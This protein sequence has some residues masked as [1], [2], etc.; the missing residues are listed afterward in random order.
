MDCLSERG[1]FQI[2]KD[3][4]EIAAL[5]EPVRSQNIY[6]LAFENITNQPG[7]LFKALVRNLY[8]YTIA[9]GGLNILTGSKAWFLVQ[10][11]TLIGVF[12]CV[13]YIKT[14]KYALLLFVLAGV[15][16]SSTIIT[17]DGGL[18]VF[19]AT[20][21][22]SAAIAAIGINLVNKHSDNSSSFNWSGSA[23]L[24]LL[25][26]LV[27]TFAIML[28]ALM[29]PLKYVSAGTENN[30][31]SSGGTAVTIIFP[32]RT[33]IHLVNNQIGSNSI[34][35]FSVEEF[36]GS[37]KVNGKKRMWPDINL[38]RLPTS[39]ISVN[40]YILLPT[41]LIRDDPHEITICTERRKWLFVEKSLLVE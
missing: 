39:L 41:E 34:S 16:L 29:T 11:P 38:K 26:G 36:L 20:V 15:L 23:R 32:A 17:E 25:F 13:R 31:C 35:S 28:T 40:K 5:S 1:V 3:H 30:K 27:L 2:V 8:L 12:W 7:L 33:A 22:F 14:P 18:R 4:P 9:N 24:A 37:L 10:L 21:P 19:A 6:A